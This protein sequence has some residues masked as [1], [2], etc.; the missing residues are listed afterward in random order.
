MNSVPFYYLSRNGCSR[1]KLF[2][3][4]DA[5]NTR[6]SQEK[7]AGI[8]I[9]NSNPS[10]LTSKLKGFSFPTI[11]AILREFSSVFPYLILK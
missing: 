11:Y 4:P 1:I 6:R 9:Y 2:F 8:W 7:K 10:F 3:A 5:K